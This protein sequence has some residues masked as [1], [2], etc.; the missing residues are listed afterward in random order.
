MNGVMLGDEWVRPAEPLPPLDVP[1]FAEQALVDERQAEADHK[2]SVE[3]LLTQ[4]VFSMATQDQPA[5]APV[6]PVPTPMDTAGLTDAFTAAL[7]TLPR[8]VDTTAELAALTKAIDKMD[9]RVAAGSMSGPGGGVSNSLLEQIRD[10]LANLVG[11]WGYMAGASGTST[12]PATARLL[13]VAAHATT[14]GTLVINGGDSIPI[15]AQTGWGLDGVFGQLVGPTLV[16]TGTD[17]YFA[18]YLT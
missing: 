10:R 12:L 9:R 5:P 16:F 2:A 6:V 13:A 18:A 8:P 11:T 14:A 7:S 4:I 15:P 1:G 17:S 3:R